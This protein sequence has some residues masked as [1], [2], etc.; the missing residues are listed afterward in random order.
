MLAQAKTCYVLN[1]AFYLYPEVKYS[2]FTV[3][4]TKKEWNIMLQFWYGE[5]EL[6]KLLRVQCPA[7]IMGWG[8]LPL[9]TF[10]YSVFSFQ[11]V[12]T[13]YWWFLISL[14]QGTQICSCKHRLS[15]FQTYLWNAIYSS[16]TSFPALSFNFGNKSKYRKSIISLT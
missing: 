4:K 16:K 5:S 8:L 15:V 14:R 11:V 3:G 9:Y 12:N 7:C 10:K 6:A 1:G 2:E 13:Y